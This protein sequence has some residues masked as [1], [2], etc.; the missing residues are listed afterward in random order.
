MLSKKI[1]STMILAISVSFSTVIMAGSFTVCGKNSIKYIGIP[2]YIAKQMIIKTTINDQ[3]QPDQNIMLDGSSCTDY[4]FVG[5]QAHVKISEKFSGTESYF[6]W[7]D[8]LPVKEGND[9]MIIY[10]CQGLLVGGVADLLDAGV[11]GTDHW[12]STTL[13][14]SEWDSLDYK[15]GNTAVHQHWGMWS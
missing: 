5:P 7:I 15:C 14:K 4:S 6:N 3:Q 8:M 13:L 2:F 11:V 9:K 1:L 12:G 10:V